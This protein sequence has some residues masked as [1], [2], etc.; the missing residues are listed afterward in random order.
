[1]FF[2]EQNAIVNA[3]LWVAGKEEVCNTSQKLG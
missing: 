3:S 2:R 1:M